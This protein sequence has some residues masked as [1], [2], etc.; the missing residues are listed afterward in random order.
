MAGELATE[1]GLGGGPISDKGSGEIESVSERPE[2]WGTS[3]PLEDGLDGLV[4]CASSTNSL[5][6]FGGTREVTV[7]FRRP[8]FTMGDCRTRPEAVAGRGALLLLLRNFL[9]CSCWVMAASPSKSISTSI[10][11]VPVELPEVV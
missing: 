6:S 7:A 3:S 5:T 4:L 2:P 9:P 1:E 11:E 8:G 10:G